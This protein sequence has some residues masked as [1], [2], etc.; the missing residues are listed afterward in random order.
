MSYGYKSVSAAT[1]TLTAS[2]YLVINKYTGPT[3]WTLPNPA[4]CNCDGRV[5]KF[6]NYGL[7]AITFSRSI[8]T[9]D[10]TTVNT[11]AIANNNNIV[12]IMSDGTEWIRVSH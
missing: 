4:T 11:L 12:E 9:D 6:V 7:S 1:Y 5:Y 2:D 3:T 8:R 10:A